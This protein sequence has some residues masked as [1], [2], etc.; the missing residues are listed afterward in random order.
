MFPI[1]NAM[2]AAPEISYSLWCDREIRKCNYVTLNNPPHSTADAAAFRW[3]LNLNI[4]LFL[5][6]LA[7]LG[8]HS[9]Y[10]W[11]YQDR[12]WKTR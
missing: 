7:L 3:T 8:Q 4:C 10:L 12:R 6:Y 11:I 1:L 9:E 5:R 2:L